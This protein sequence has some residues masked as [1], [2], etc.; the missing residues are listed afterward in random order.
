MTKTELIGRA[1]RAKTPEELMLIAKANSFDMS[2]E[3]AK[4]YFARFSKVGELSDDDLCN[5]S[6]GGCYSG[7]GRLVVSVLYSCDD[8]I[9]HCG[10]T[11]HKSNFEGIVDTCV[12]CN[13]TY[14][15]KSCKYCSYEKGLWLCNKHRK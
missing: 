4:A 9:C 14:G 13:R 11:T 7:D 15:C 1:R 10:G 12:N 2:E 8:W 5:V 3:E 6:G